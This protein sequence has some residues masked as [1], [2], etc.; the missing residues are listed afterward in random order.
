M[1][2]VATKKEPS[3]KERKID[4]LSFRGERRTARLGIRIEPSLMIAIAK[5]AA[6]EGRDPSDFARRI[7]ESAVTKKEA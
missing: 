5:A 1:F 4:L 6:A 2:T 3:G 7:L